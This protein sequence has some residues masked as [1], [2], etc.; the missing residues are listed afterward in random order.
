MPTPA[1]VRGALE[2]SVDVL[3]LNL[4]GPQVFLINR[5]TM[6]RLVRELA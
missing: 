6:E 1:I 2:K 4:A 3:A 5:L